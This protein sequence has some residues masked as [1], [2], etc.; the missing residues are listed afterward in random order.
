MKKVL[1]AVFLIVGTIIGAGFAS[2]REIS[3]FFARFGVYSLFFLPILF[4]IF[5]YVF[6]LL[7]S[8][9]KDKKFDNIYKLHA[10]TKNS[11]FMNALICLTFIVFT[12]AMFSGAVE[13]LAINFISVPAIVFYLVLIVICYFVLKFGFKGLVKLNAVLVPI[14]IFAIITLCVFATFS[15]VTDATFIPENTKVYELPLSILLYAMSNILLSYYL[16][17][18]AGNTLDEKAI[19]KVSFISSTIICVVIFISIVCLI[20]NGSAIMETDMPF[21]ALSYRMGELFN[22]FFSTM[23]LMA[24]LTTLF[25]GL[26]TTYEALPFKKA[27]SIITIFFVI[28]LSLLG[29]K[30]I[31][32]YIYP[33]IGIVGISVI[34]R[35]CF[36]YKSFLKSGFNSSH[37]EIHSPC[38]DA[39]NKGCSHNK[40]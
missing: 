27:K 9:G 25:S 28:A 29:F 31:V 36:S 7:L 19:K 17:I 35:L 34:L 2:G 39:K 32:N 30:Q 3:V 37:N 6:K 26:F 18:K 4:L 21:V 14:L 5:Y 12:S 23:V 40:V 16:I 38:Q 13:I 8:I 22:I 11:V 1:P 15:P 33:I 10:F 20:K 24:I